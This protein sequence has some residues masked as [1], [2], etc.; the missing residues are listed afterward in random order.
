MKELKS[1]LRVMNEVVDTISK[2]IVYL[3]VEDIEEVLACAQSIVASR[4]P[5]FL[6]KVM[7]FFTRKKNQAITKG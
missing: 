1:K 2:N 3:S 6:K 4:K 5:S 7:M